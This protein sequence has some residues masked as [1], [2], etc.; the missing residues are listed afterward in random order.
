MFSDSVLVNPEIKPKKSS[1]NRWHTGCVDKQDTPMAFQLI[2][3][4]READKSGQ[5]M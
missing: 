5:I 2:R 1:C 3:I 4:K